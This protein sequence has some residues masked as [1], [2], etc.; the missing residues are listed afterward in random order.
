MSPAP[1]TPIGLAADPNGNGDQQL[2]EVIESM[3][4]IQTED[5]RWHLAEKLAVLIPSGSSGFD[6]VLDKAASEGVAGGLSINTL[7][8]YRDT[9][10]RWAA[11]KRVRNV[12]FSAHRESMAMP[13]ID[14]AARMLADMARTQG[15]DKVTVA[16]VRKAVAIKQGKAPK[17]APAKPQT[18]TVDHVLDDLKAGGKELIQ[19]IPAATPLSELDE[20]QAG[21]NKVLQHVE[22]LRAKA[23]QKAQAAAKKAIPE[24]RKAL[25]DASKKE[26]TA[27]PAKAAGARKGDLRGL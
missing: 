27:A 15:A 26:P 11:D 1:I 24:A 4:S 16:S 14:E 10:N 5:D 23:S 21:L 13:S 8:L 17:P 18:T 9:A 7:R 25:A 2:D 20:L 3:R 12:S 6:K 19:G 22:R